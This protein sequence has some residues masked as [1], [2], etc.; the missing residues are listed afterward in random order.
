MR[1][2][3]HLALGLLLACLAGCPATGPDD[4][5]GDDDNDP[6][7]PDD[8][9]VTPPPT[10]T[11]IELVDRLGAA[12]VACG[13][14]RVSTIPGGWESVAV[15]DLGCMVWV[16]GGW[17]VQGEGTAIASLFAD[18]SGRE[19]ALGIAGAT[20]DLPECTPVA[21]RD[22]V[23]AGFADSGYAEPSIAWHLESIEPFGGT[24]WPTAQAVFQSAVGGTPLVGYLW[25][26]TTPTVVA[27]DVVALGFW[28]PEA[29]IEAD[30][31]TVL[32]ILNS[33]TCPSGGGCDDA[34]CDQRCRGEGFNGGSCGLGC[35]CF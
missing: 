12:A 26:L 15:G 17:I 25:V 18:E 32:Q 31:C 2:L 30:T 6:G 27:C 13:A 28:E 33:V 35:E 21:A 3:P 1:H 34:D 14:Q 23:L 8:S 10:G 9:T 19:G 4:D 16:P 24:D 22:S 29:R 11:G 5:G 20:Q 7:D